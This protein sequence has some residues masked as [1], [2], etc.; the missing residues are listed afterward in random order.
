MNKNHRADS[1]HI[2]ESYATIL[3]YSDLQSV[4]LAVVGSRVIDEGMTLFVKRGVE[5]WQLREEDVCAFHALDP[6]K[7]KGPPSNA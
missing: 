7:A 6:S 4:R 2:E 3:P 1:V 5:T